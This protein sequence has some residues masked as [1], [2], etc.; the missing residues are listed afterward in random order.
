MI[1]LFCKLL[2][3][4]GYFMNKPYSIGLDIGTNSVGWAV[5]TDDYKVPSKKMKVEGNTDKKYIK[6]NLLGSLL[7]EGGETAKETRT[8]RGQRRRYTRRRNRLI[9]L[10]E[11]FKS[12]MDKVDPNFFMRLEESFLWP[13]DKQGSKHPI[14]GTVKEEVEYHEAFPTIYHLRKELADSDAKADIRLVYLALAHIIKY[15]GHFLFEKVDPKNANLKGNFSKFVEVYNEV[16]DDD[17][18][19]SVEVE[20]ILGAKST[21]SKKI[22]DILN[23]YPGLKKADLFAKFISLAVGTSV[24][25]QKEFELE[26]ECKLQIPKESFE[27]DLEG[28]QGQIPDE[29]FEVLYAAK[30]LYDSILLSSILTDISGTNAPLSSSMIRRFKEH[31]EDLEQLKRFFKSHSNYDYNSFFNDN[32]KPYYAGYIDGKTS[33][34][35]FYKAV[36]KLFEKDHDANW[37]IDKID[38]EDFLRKQRT[39]DNGAIPHQIHLAELKAI[40]E[41]QKKYYPF[42]EKEADRIESILTFRIPYYVGPL[43]NGY[44]KFGWVVR[45]GNEAIKPWNL[46]E[47]IDK[48]ATA[49]RF[50]TRMTNRCTYLPSENV[51]PKHSLLYEKFM[52]FN[53]LTKIRYVLENNKHFAVDTEMKMKIFEMLFKKNRKVKEKQLLAFFDKEYPDFHITKVMGLDR[54][55]PEF[56]SSYATYHDLKKIVSQEYLDNPENADAIEDIIHTLTLFEDREIIREKL[57]VYK[58]YFT[59]EQL[60]KLERR[61]YTGWG[62]LSKKLIC[63][64]RDKQTHKTIMEFLE[65]DGYSNRNL[66]QLVTADELSFAK[67]I[68]D[69]SSIDTTLSL[70]EL[71]QEIPGS[72]AIKK[73]IH[74]S[75][76]IVEEIRRVMGYDPENIVIE[77]ARE[78]QTTAEGERRS[79]ERMRILEKALGEFEGKVNVSLPK[80]NKLLSNNRL[81]LYYL[82]NGKDIYSGADLDINLLS[83][84]DIDHIIPQSFIKDDSLDNI[85]LTTSEDNRG[86]LDNVPSPEVVRKMKGYWQ[87]LLKAKLISDRKYN[88]LTKAE[89][90]GLTEED[91]KTFIRRQLVETRQITKHVAR[92]LDE[93]F[94]HE[95]NESGEPIRKVRVITLKSKLVSDFRKKFE[96]YKVREINDFHHAHDAYLNAVVGT[97][98]LKKYPKLESEFVYGAFK[99]FETRKIYEKATRRYLFYSNI[100]NFLN[101]PLEDRVTEDGELIWDNNKDLPNIKKCLYVPQ[102]NVVKKTEVQTVGQNGGLFDNNI[103]PRTKIK[104]PEKYVEI[105]KN[106]GL[107]VTK[108]GGYSGETIAYSVFVVG[109]RKA[110]NGK[111]KAVKELV[112][113]TVRNQKQYE[114]NKLKYLLNMGFEEINPSLLFE[115]PKYTLFQMEDGRKRMLASSTELQKANMIYF[116]EKFVKLLYHAKNISDENSKIHENYL[117]EHR[118]EFLSLFKIIIEFSKKYIVKDKVE[119]KLVNV[120]EKEFEAASIHQLS[121]SFVNLLEYVNRGPASQFNFLGVVINRENLRYQTVT[122]C[123]NAIV[124]FESITG[125]YET[126]INLSK[127]G[128]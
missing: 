26:N 34:V 16:F 117:S 103:V 101:G 35:E 95:K 40:I 15:R 99:K 62:K 100:L 118:N 127:Y 81:Y 37:I 94:N 67:E 13:E 2:N 97:L 7:F 24:S 125:L 50:I 109:K 28:L 73:G 10:Q 4:G 52:V 75:L 53:E 45:K 74:Q 17:K 83:T 46:E 42:L 113:I 9:Y 79:R 47:Q 89:R 86:K 18:D 29:F 12:E 104:N 78:A 1:K 41:K 33:Q 105:K 70:R 59:R 31:K 92:I 76:K 38:R 107:D 121:E 80:E 48:S 27:E 110:K 66:M 39:F 120:V 98:L 21:K 115:F 128:E 36:K 58:D 22:E 32:T 93:R 119:Q 51:L 124:C 71:V 30:A 68:K 122:E 57:S 6:K 61:H 102:V 63:G 14:F 85:V 69:A 87:Q 3:L 96:L 65:D 49:E 11:I 108:Y 123:L 54:K 114:N 112:G 106:K 90:G 84:Y 19:C 77:M 91:K 111:I 116:E 60:K 25:F 88:N 20:S 23:L 126:R 8:K 43:S 44:S 82:Q 55:K 64:I 72:P 56:N 5:I